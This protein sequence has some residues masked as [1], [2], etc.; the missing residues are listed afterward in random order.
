MFVVVKKEDVTIG[1]YVV[2]YS[3]PGPK[4][5]IKNMAD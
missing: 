1:T 3:H 4:R 2:M 5:A